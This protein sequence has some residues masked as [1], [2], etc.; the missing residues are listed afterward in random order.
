MHQRESGKA[1]RQTETMGQSHPLILHYK[2]S[3]MRLNA[4]R[5]RAKNCQQACVLMRSNRPMA[6][7]LFQKQLQYTLQRVV[8]E[9]EEKK[10]KISQ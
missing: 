6:G 5:G 2:P 10:G 3:P 8:E 1:H 9:A 4:I 7:G